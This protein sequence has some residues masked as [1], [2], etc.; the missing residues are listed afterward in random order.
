LGLLYKGTATKPAI[1]KFDLIARPLY[2]KIFKQSKL[3]RHIDFNQG[4]DARLVTD[5]K[6]KKLSEVN[7][8]PLRIAFD[9]YAMHKIYIK[10]VEL[11][12][13]YGIKNLSNYLL[14][15]FNDK[16]QDLYNRMK[17]NV[18]LCEK[19]RISIYSFPM[20]YH[21]IDDPNY[22]RNRDYIGKH[23]NRKF[24][25][26]IQA[27]LNATKG[28]IGRGKSFFQEAFGKNIKEFE[29]IL[30]MPE[31]FI[32]YRMKYKD[33]L[34]QQWWNKFQALPNNKK[35]KLKN[36]VKK[37]DFKNIKDLTQDNDILEVL[38]Y[39]TISRNAIELV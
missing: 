28:K 36:I 21:P 35:Q 4:I 8:Y 2:E 17:I 38:Q 6:M 32:I 29:K 10:A 15:N 12:A 3:T 11:A 19:L 30:Y 33:G 1:I 13:K 7:I 37:N 24:I 23:W 26:A 27:V 20:K 31:A 9:H 39:Y 14:Y 34:T 18:F 22:F 16:P 25:R 5:Q